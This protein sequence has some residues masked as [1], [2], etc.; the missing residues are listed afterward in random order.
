MGDPIKIKV[1]GRGGKTLALGGWRLSLE[2][3]QP[4]LIIEDRSKLPS[5]YVARHDYWNHFKR[6]KY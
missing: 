3:W 5:G 6:K 4:F 1:G 2:E